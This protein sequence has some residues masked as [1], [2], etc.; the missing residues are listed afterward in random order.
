MDQGKNAQ[1]RNQNIRFDV[2][3]IAKRNVSLGTGSA[4]KT[5]GNFACRNTLRRSVGYG[6]TLSVHKRQKLSPRDDEKDGFQN[7]WYFFRKCFYLQ[8]K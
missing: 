3:F 6:F 8:S 2:D 7:Q 5:I 4:P 1:Y